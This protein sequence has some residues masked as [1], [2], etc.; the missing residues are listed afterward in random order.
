MHTHLRSYDPVVR[1][2]GD[3]FVC[4]LVDCTLHRA[5][6]RFQQIRAEIEQT[7]PATSI[8]VGFAPLRPRTPWSSS[9]NAVIERSTR[10]SAPEADHRE[11]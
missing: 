9:P 4:A 1:V 6:E 10:S 5:G 8:S 2:G 7:R 11:R 3:E